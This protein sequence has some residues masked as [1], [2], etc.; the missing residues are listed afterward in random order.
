MTELPRHEGLTIPAKVNYVSKGENLHKLGFKPAGDAM[1][2]H[3][4]L[5]TTWL[6][7]K[8]RVQGG[9]YGGYCTFDRR[10]GVFIYSSYRDPNL[11]K[12]LDLY[13]GSAAFLREAALGE[14]DL[15]RAI[16]GTIGRID[17]YR[18]PD[19]KGF[20]SLQWYLTND[21]DEDRQRIREEVLGT[22]AAGIRDLAGALDAV[23]K[24]GRVVVVGS[25]EA[26]AEA[27]AG[28]DGMFTVS[29]VL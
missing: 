5:R 21:S 13:D 18:L 24:Q 7:D 28:R 25:E 17:T 8:V 14:T 6:W 16:I 29:K 2:A 10:S 11:L 27:N 1:V 26:I 4:Y 19:A 15:V 3:H 9:A 20:T 12:T 22:T 23:A